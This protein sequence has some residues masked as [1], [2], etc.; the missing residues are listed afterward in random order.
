[1]KS[2]D[3]LNE[4]HFDYL[5]QKIIDSMAEYFARDHLDIYQDWKNDPEADHPGRPEKFFL[6]HEEFQEELNGFIENLENKIYNRTAQ[7]QKQLAK[8]LR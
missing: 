7:I 6:D 8:E 2:N 3:I 4:G 1:M 5:K